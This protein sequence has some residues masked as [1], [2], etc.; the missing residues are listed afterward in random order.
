ML[1]QCRTAVVALAMIV[2]MSSSTNA[3]AQSKDERKP[4]KK[5]AKK[6][7]PEE[8]RAK[9]E[10]ELPKEDGKDVFVFFTSESS[11]RKATDEEFATEGPF[12]SRR[13]KKAHSVEGRKSAVDM[14]VEFV[15]PKPGDTQ[16][17]K[18]ADKDKVMLG[19]ILEIK[20]RK[21][22]FIAAFPKTEQGE[23]EVAASLEAAKKR[24]ADE[25]KEE[26]KKR[27]KR[28]KLFGGDGY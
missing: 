3:C 4:A 12:V 6:K 21:W 19:D 17:R 9:I 8:I 28:K 22:E 2:A 5:V 25:E 15:S 1:L 10:S 18:G 26:D 7:T 14:L 27:A 16:L 20:Q 11:M 13:S 23:K 24:I